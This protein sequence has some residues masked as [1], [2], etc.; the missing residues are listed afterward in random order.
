MAGAMVKIAPTGAASNKGL[1][2]LSTSANC[3]YSTSG[4]EWKSEPGHVLVILY[5]EQKC[6][7][8]R[9]GA[10]EQ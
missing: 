1:G 2:P 10:R 3:D 6:I 8:R 7:L 4:H 9:A 5:R